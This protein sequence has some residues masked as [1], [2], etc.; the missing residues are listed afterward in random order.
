MPPRS[1]SGQH[2]ADEQ[3]VPDVQWHHPGSTLSFASGSA[4]KRITA[5]VKARRGPYPAKVPICRSGLHPPAES[6]PNEKRIQLSR[7]R[8][9]PLSLA[10]LAGHFAFFV[11][12]ERPS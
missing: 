5:G 6:V 8:R 12:M 4:L 1:R 11:H 9:E 7:A 10:T 2:Q 3:L